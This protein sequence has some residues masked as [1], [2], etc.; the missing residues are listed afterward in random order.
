MVPD[1]LHSH[2][3]PVFLHTHT[4][5]CTYSSWHPT[6]IHKLFLT[7]VIPICHEP[8]IASNTLHSH[9]VLTYCIR[10]LFLTHIIH[11]QIVSDIL[12]TYMPRIT[13]CFWHPA[14]TY[15]PH[16]LYSHSVSHTLHTAQLRWKAL[17]PSLVWVHCISEVWIL[18]CTYTCAYINIYIYVCI[19]SHVYITH[20]PRGLHVSRFIVFRRRVFAY[21]HIHARI[22]IYIHICIY[23]CAYI[24][25]TYLP[26][27]L[28]LS[29]FM[30]FGGVYLYTYIHM[31][32]YQYTYMYVYVYIYVYIHIRP[33]PSL[34]WVHCILEVYI[35]IRTCILVRISIYVHVYICNIYIYA[36]GLHL[37]GFNVFRRYVFLYV[38][39][40]IYC[41]SEVYIRLWTYTCAYINTHTCMYMYIYIYTYTPQAS[42][43]VGSLY[44][45]SIYSYIYVHI[46]VRTSIYINVYICIYTYTYTP[47]AF[48]CLGSMYFGG[49]Y[50]YMYIH[51]CVHQYTY[52]YTWHDLTRCILEVYICTCT[53]T[54][55]LIYIC[56]YI[57]TYKYTHTYLPQ[58]LHLSGF[59]VLQMYAFVYVGLFC[60]ILSLS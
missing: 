11:P 47:E 30:D 4:S 51:M 42:T 16:T 10:I 31:C 54:C 58:G 20:L 26:W 8:H 25:I 41:I 50:L 32:V 21:V 55:T 28:H 17:R 59:I 15:C 3:V 57:Y 13:H 53:C 56:L 48:T 37:S 24:Y 49:M 34:V 2:R 12:H 38:H 18:I 35:C 45:R 1:T 44:F 23:I 5:R 43:C 9:T 7:F 22:S 36:R 52:T 27:G 39:I 29:R 14:F 6:S 19:Y 60:R 40:S 33:R 46:H